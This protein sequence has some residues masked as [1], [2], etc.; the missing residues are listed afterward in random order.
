[1]ILNSN[2]Y[3]TIS[4]LRCIVPSEDADPSNL[5]VQLNNLIYLDKR[6]SICIVN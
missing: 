5:L 6:D 3:Y 1:M 2:R 4:L